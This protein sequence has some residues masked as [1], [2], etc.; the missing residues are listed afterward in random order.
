MSARRIE[1]HEVGQASSLFH[2][3]R[4]A[5][6]G[7]TAV[8]RWVEIL[9]LP[10]CFGLRDRLEACPTKR[11]RFGPKPGEGRGGLLP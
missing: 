4:N 6:H 2:V 1:S 3:L 11:D 8:N 9:V 5:P 10:G 7:P